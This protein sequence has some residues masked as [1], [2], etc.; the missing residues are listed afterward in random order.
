[1]AVQ[2]VYIPAYLRGVHH[3]SPVS[4]GAFSIAFVLPLLLATAGVG[5]IPSEIC[6][7]RYLL[8][9]GWALNIVTCGCLILIGTA[10]KPGVCAILII[11]TGLGHGITISATHRALRVLSIQRAQSTR[12]AFLIANFVRTVGFCLAI[13]GGESVFQTRMNVYYTLYTLTKVYADTFDD[14][15][16]A[17][18]TLAGIGGL[19]SLFVGWRKNRS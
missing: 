15:M 3:S 19:L 18:T 8:L 2:L 17:L 16:R 10:T 9:L 14:L 12:D 11:F 4:I 5:L 7:F 6:H 1:M 13:S